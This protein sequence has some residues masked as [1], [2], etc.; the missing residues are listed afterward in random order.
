[1]VPLA[2]LGDPMLYPAP[3]LRLDRPSRQARPCCRF[4]DLQLPSPSN[5]RRRK[6]PNRSASEA[7][8]TCLGVVIRRDCQTL[9]FHPPRSSPST[10]RWLYTRTRK[11]I[12]QVS[13]AIFCD[14]PWRHRHAN[15]RI[16]VND[17]A[18]G[19]AWRSDVY[20]RAGVTVRSPSRQ[21]RPCCRFPD[22]S[23]P[24]RSG[25]QEQRSPCPSVVVKLV[26]PVWV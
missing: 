4:L 22:R 7:G 20:T 1:M 13:C 26:A 21:V 14:R 8:S 17:G 3:E 24:W 19:R 25:C 11:G 18:A 2:E 15:V 6:L 16:V 9:H 10:S 12:D 5:Y 23:L